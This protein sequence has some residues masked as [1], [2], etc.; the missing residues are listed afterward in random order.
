MYRIIISNWNRTQRKIWHD[1]R[2]SRVLRRNKSS[3]YFRNAKIRIEIR[4]KRFL[5]FPLSI[6][7]QTCEPF[8]PHLLIPFLSS[9]ELQLQEAVKFPSPPP[10]FNLIHCSIDRIRSN[11]AEHIYIYILAHRIYPFA[12]ADNCI[13][14]RTRIRQRTIATG[15]R[16]VNFL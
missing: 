15:G 11:S 10:S 8:F 3:Y 14:S 5:F 9:L 7:N 16:R 4:I 2:R 1:F 12:A 13:I 6:E